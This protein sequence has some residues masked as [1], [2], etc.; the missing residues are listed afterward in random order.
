MPHDSVACRLGKMLVPC[1]TSQRSNGNTFMRGAC[2]QKLKDGV[3]LASSDWKAWVEAARTTV[4]AHL[5]DGWDTEE[6]H[7]ATLVRPSDCSRRLRPGKIGEGC[8]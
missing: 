8:R 7:R 2:L 6:C 3:A 5:E 1:R 4:G